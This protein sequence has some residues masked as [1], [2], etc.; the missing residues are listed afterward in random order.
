M[1]QRNEDPGIP[2]LTQRAPARHDPPVL[3]QTADDLPPWETAAPTQAAYAHASSP[4]SSP[5][6]PAPSAFA[7][8]SR[9]ATPE[10]PGRPIGD[11]PAAQR[12]AADS[13]EQPSEAVLRAAL[14]A[15]IEDAVQDALEEAMHL[16][17]A[18]LEARIPEIVTQAVRRTRM[19]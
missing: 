5:H 7:Y 18:R 1:T 10:G 13:R 6:T 14:Q 17:R 2:T 3:T 11:V 4:A 12:P 9:G 15:D 19:G 8:A 16:M